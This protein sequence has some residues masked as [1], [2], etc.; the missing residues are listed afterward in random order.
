MFLPSG[1]CTLVEGLIKAEDVCDEW[2]AIKADKG[3]GMAIHEQLGGGQSAPAAT[4]TVAP[5]PEQHVSQQGVVDE[6]IMMQDPTLID[7][8]ETGAGAAQ[9]KWGTT[10]DIGRCVTLATQTLG[11]ENSRTFCQVRYGNMTGQDASGL[12]HQAPSGAGGGN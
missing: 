7:F 5:A 8:F 3:M 1:S 11:L 9:I 4:P 6:S 10:G 2:D 12:V